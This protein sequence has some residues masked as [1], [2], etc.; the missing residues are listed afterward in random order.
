MKNI[1]LIP[2]VLM[3]TSALLLFKAIGLLTHGSYV[4]EGTQSVV[5]QSGP[6]VADGQALAN[7][8]A[9]DVASAGGGAGDGTGDGAGN[10]ASTDA[11]KLSRLDEEAARRAA[12]SLFSATNSPIP[13]NGQSDALPVVENS[14]GQ[15]VLFTTEDGTSL[16]EEAILQRLRDRR[17]ELDAR[18][19]QLD[20]QAALV[21]A[22]EIKLDEQ[23]ARLEALKAEVQGLLEQQGKAGEQQFEALV[24]MYSNMKPADAAK[25]FDSLD[26]GVLLRLAV[27]MS[28]RKMSPILAAMS[29]ERAQELTLKMAANP[30]G[31]ALA[32]P[33]DMAPSDGGEL[34]QIV[35]Q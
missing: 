31:V 27:K 3:A 33:Q 7:P 11:L 16:T 22:A 29:V 34:P 5:A 32:G 25:V 28:P 14:D 18:A 2:I 35:G 21:K 19:E 1:R 13:D 8:A 23:V 4:I 9:P 17:V 26:M 30:T 15:H 24:S 6:V 10:G 12:D 20:M